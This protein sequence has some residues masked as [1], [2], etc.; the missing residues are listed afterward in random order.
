MSSIEAGQ[1][2]R[3]LVARKSREKSRSV[4]EISPLPAIQNPQRRRTC[5]KDLKAFCLEYFPKRFYLPF[6]SNHME[7]VQRLEDMMIRQNG[8]LA[9]AMPRGYGKS[10]LVEATVI[11]ALL[12]GYCR[13]IVIIAANSRES[14][15]FI[16]NI[17]LALTGN[18]SLREDFPESVYPFYK[19]GG[20]AALARGQRYLGELT[21]IEWKPDGVVFANIPGSPA[22]GS[23]FLSV[24][25]RGA[26][27]GGNKTMPD[28]S[29]ARPNCVILDDPQTEKDAHSPIQVDKLMGIID[30][31]IEGL[32]G[33]A[34]HLAMVM[35]C[36]VI[37][38]GDLASL[39]LDHQKKP[40]WKGLRFKM[41]E[42]MP[43][44]MDLWE[45][46]RDLRNEDDAKAT[47]FYRQHRA[48]MQEGAVVPWKE[49]HTADE[50]D[51]L[52]FA[53]NKWSDNETMFF[54]EYQNEPVEKSSETLI[55]PSKTIKTRLNGMER[56]MIPM[57][58]QVITAF[59]DVH[60]DLIYYMIAAWSGDFTGYVI[61]YGVFPE[62]TRGNFSRNDKS[63][64]TL[65]R[66]FGEK[67]SDGAIAAGLEFLLHQ[68]MQECYTMHGDSAKQEINR[69]DKIL[70]DS[71][72]KP[73]VIESVIMK[74]GSPVHVRPSL[75]VGVTAKQAP[76]MH[77]GQRPHHA[78]LN[79]NAGKGKSVRV[80]HFWIEEKLQKRMYRT[81]KGD[82]NY[83][84]SAVHDAFSLRSGERGSITFW[85][86]N[87]EAH[88]MV[89][90][91]MTAETV[92]FVEANSR[93][94][95]EW[96]NP[97]NRDNH[98]FD[99]MVGC[100]IAASTL[101]IRTAEETETATL[102]QTTRITDLT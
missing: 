91:H 94:V 23:M 47:E 82:V 65:R 64:I 83:W 29:L 15:K 102:H 36:T 33:P 8:K 68:L 13:Y 1:R 72:Y 78:M 26:I 100:M 43:T 57:D 25:I 3:E 97:F 87:P 55:V 22:S 52:Q 80:G 49:N 95:N 61:D 20:S 58:T 27:R 6:S 71:G 66:R 10:A 14:K 63:L 86:S 28:G 90:E 40:R 12:Y 31:G 19:L 48:E 53:M 4:Q 70:I 41:I 77:W 44:R 98:W 93:K 76:M 96:S 34:A 38:E 37:R 18:K 5:R 73:H 81:T 32:V 88:R 2:H 74:I 35:T 67:R 54:S 51:A 16:T 50:L 24:G 62:Q 7:V 56:R 69:I 79:M 101:G 9:L 17:K 85:G 60:K 21:G 39:Y 92:V 99:C 75:G 89:S 42:Q 30:Q 45:H 84:K 59:C 11:W 46:Y